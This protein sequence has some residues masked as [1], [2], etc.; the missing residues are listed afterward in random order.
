MIG[1]YS[2]EGLRQDREDRERQREGQAQGSS[3][4]QVPLDAPY[5]DPDAVLHVWTGAKWIPYE[6]WLATAP[7]VV[8]QIPEP[9]APP[10]EEAKE[11]KRE[12]VQVH[13]PMENGNHG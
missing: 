3:L 4:A 11:T 7:I 9:I 13:L 8:E 12:P 6:K 10:K 2:L 1:F 5:E